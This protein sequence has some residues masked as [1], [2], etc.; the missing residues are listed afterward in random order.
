MFRQ[1]DDHTQ[2]NVRPQLE[3]EDPVGSATWKALPAS[4]QHHCDDALSHG[5]FEV[6]KCDD[7]FPDQEFEYNFAEMTVNGHFFGARP[8]MTWNIRRI[9][10]I[11]S[12]DTSSTNL[13]HQPT[14]H[15]ER[16]RPLT[17]YTQLQ[18]NPLTSDNWIRQPPHWEYEDPVRS[19]RWKA[20]PD[21][22]QTHCDYAFEHANYKI[23]KNDDACSQSQ[24]LYNFTRWKL[25][26]TSTIAATP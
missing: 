5:A 2:L 20:L 10:V 11:E 14:L 16:R 24:F 21:S 26:D 19:G 23:Y 18:E 7:D 15:T 22:D 1:C 6:C 12:H 8:S 4:H 17:A 3:Y 25:P 9:Q 13:R